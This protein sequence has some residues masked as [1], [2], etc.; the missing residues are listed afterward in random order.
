MGLYA[1]LFSLLFAM[2][3]AADE[4][5]PPQS[6]ASDSTS[7]SGLSL[8]AYPYAYYTPETELAFGAGGILIFYTARDAIIRPSKVG[9]SGYYSTNQQY[10][11]SA[12]PELYFLR[13]N[14]FV[15]VHLSFGHFVDKFWGIG[16]A[17][18][19]TGEEDYTRDGFSAALTIQAPPLLFAADRSGLS[20]DYDYTEIEDKQSNQF[21][22]GDE[23]PGS[24][25]AHLLGFGYDLTWDSRDHIFFPNSGY[26][27]Y[28]N[29]TIYPRRN[30]YEFYLL[31]LDV[32]QYKAF[33][34]NQVLAGH[35]YLAAAGGETPFYKLP[36]LGGQHRMRG[37]FE[38]R[39]RD[40]FYATLQVEYRQYF[41]RRLGFVVFAGAGDVA[42]DMLSLN[43]DDFKYSYGG[44][45]RFL[46][47]QE[48]RVNIRMDV[49]FGSNGSNG[50]YFGI[51]EAF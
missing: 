9:L 2:G 18:E 43:S 31:E 19:E 32:R 17:T 40:N 51:E 44:G 42:P 16:N 1:L 45:L 41:W 50:I 36:A 47:D 39:Y 30:D 5:E 29:L 48:Q 38:G 26:Y 25:G 7:T 28:F 46:F 24:N 15:R 35:F 11:I 3:A 21:L 33:A 14:L 20:I 22:T 12:S 4:T 6:P 13:N 34:P 37:Y 8:S 27:Q 10:K 49:G 23:V